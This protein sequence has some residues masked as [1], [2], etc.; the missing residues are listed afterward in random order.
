Q[1]PSCTWVTRGR[2]SPVVELVET[3]GPAPA[4]VQAAARRSRWLGWLLWCGFA[5]GLD[6]GAPMALFATNTPTWGAG[7]AFTLG[8]VASVRASPHPQSQPSPLPSIAAA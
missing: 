4:G 6:L 1:P 3:R 7:P 8:R 5:R 2:R